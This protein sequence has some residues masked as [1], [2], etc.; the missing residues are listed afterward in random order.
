MLQDHVHNYFCDIHYEHF[1]SIITYSLRAYTSFC[2]A[3]SKQ[4][5]KLQLSTN[6]HEFPWE[7]RGLSTFIIGANL[8]IM[9]FL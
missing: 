3:I 7:S 9:P 1:H 4:G 6:R 8:P 5:Y 2:V